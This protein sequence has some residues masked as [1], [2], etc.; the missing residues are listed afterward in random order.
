MRHAGRLCPKV[1]TGWHSLPCGP[2]FGALCG[3]RQREYLIKTK[4]VT[5]DRHARVL[6]QLLLCGPLTFELLQ[7]KAKLRRSDD[8]FGQV[9]GD[10][11]EK[12]GKRNPTKPV[13]W[14][15]SELTRCYRI[16]PSALKFAAAPLAETVKQV[17]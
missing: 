7:E 4:P 15:S 5:D 11:A 9:M 14:W 12:A 13:E 10:L 2:F 17:K 6:E 8:E 16:R 3:E 1:S